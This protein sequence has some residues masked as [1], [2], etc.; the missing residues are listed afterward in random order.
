VEGA[1]KNKA[2]A[3]RRVSSAPAPRSPLGKSCARRR[4]CCECP[5]CCALARVRASAARPSL[6]D[7]NL[8]P[9]CLRCA[10]GRVRGGCEWSRRC[11]GGGV[12]RAALSLGLPSQLVFHSHAGCP[13]MAVGLM[14][15]GMQ[16]HSLDTRLVTLQKA[17]RR[18]DEGELRAACL[19]HGAPQHVQVLLV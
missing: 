9:F 17:R 4:S 1:K 18:Q 8:A 11:G 13:C 7:W 2:A 3:W 16:C 10:R 14:L 12:S 6:A 5:P 15:G 19:F